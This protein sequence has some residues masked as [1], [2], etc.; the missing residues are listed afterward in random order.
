VSVLPDLPVAGC[1]DST[2]DPDR[3]LAQL[4]TWD[5]NL[6]VGSAALLAMAGPMGCA[7]AILALANA[8][9]ETCIEAFDGDA[10]AQRR[11]AGPHGVAKAGFP[12]GIK[13]LTAARWGIPAHARMG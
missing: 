5:G 12:H 9:P 3:L 10:K 13:S 2:G 4:D 8:E 6:Y 1:K 7:G 11:L